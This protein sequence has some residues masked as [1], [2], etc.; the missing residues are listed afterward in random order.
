[1]DPE[2]LL[3]EIRELIFQKLEREVLRTNFAP[4]SICTM[5]DDTSQYG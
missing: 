4:F 5:P 2:L 3:T 1:M